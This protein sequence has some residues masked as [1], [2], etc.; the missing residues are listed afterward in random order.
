MARLTTVKEL[1]GAWTDFSRLFP[2]GCKRDTSRVHPYFSKM[3]EEFSRH[4]WQGLSRI[5]SIEQN[6]FLPQPVAE[7]CDQWLEAVERTTG[8]KFLYPLPAALAT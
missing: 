6:K 7:L 4:F 1:N 3:S 2:P 5:D 8:V